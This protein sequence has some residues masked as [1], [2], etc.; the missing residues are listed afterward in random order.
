MEFDFNQLAMHAE[1]WLPVVLEHAI[2]LTLAFTTLAVGWWLI[3]TVTG[4]VGVLLGNRKVDKTL[5]GFIG[6]LVNTA[7]KIMLIISVA[8]MI[9]IQT[10]SFV[11]A[12]G[13]AGLA[14]GLALQGSLSNFAGGVLV[15]LF[16][17]YKVGDTVEVQGVYGTV[18][19]I[20]IFHTVIL[21]VD[22]KRII[23]PNG[24]ISN[25]VIINY[26]SEPL[27]KVV[28]DVGVDRSANLD[29]ARQVLL[30]MAQDPRVLN[31]PAPLVVVTTLGDNAITLSLRV[32]ALNADYWDLTFMFNEQVRDALAQE[33]ISIPYPQR[34]VTLLNS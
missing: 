20:L 24:S 22:N 4:R 10:T 7:L 5:Q 17:P 9:G 30:K 21:S 1:T 19:T 2:S 11:A 31:E 26:S 12:L 3:S 32:W 34:V 29:C 25:G 15:L 23:V 33:H 27:R 13:A 16:R 8:S 6:N 28:F 14:I 18:E